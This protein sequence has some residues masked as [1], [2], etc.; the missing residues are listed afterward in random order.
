MNAPADRILFQLKTRGPA[1][2]L[3]LAGALDIS[4]QAVL[5]HL[6]R[7]VAGGLVDHLDERRGVGRPRRIW[8]LTP[9]AQARFPDTHAQLTLEMLD[10]VRAEF[11]E[12]GVQRMIVRR[13][14]A[15]AKAYVQAMASAESLEAR[16]ARLAEIR[17]AEGYMADWTPDPGGGFLF[18]ENHC[19]ICA[20]AA[21][22]QGFCRAELQVFREALGPGVSVERTDHILAGARRCAYRITS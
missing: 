16:V 14:Q 18:V 8:A 22:C 9:A 4:R 5:Q 3:A 1:E 13:E 2:T 17:T 12:A 20:A 19:P 7:L 10:A 21:A 11:G 6:E 15:T